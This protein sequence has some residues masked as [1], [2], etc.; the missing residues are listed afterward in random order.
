[1]ALPLPQK[2]L[3]T[4]LVWP[5]NK[6][7]N[8]NSRMQN[9]CYLKFTYNINKEDARDMCDKVRSNIRTCSSLKVVLVP[10]FFK[11]CL[12]IVL[13]LLIL[14]ARDHL[15]LSVDRRLTSMASQSWTEFSRVTIMPLHNSS[16]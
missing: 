11:F 1:M 6:Y 9:V 16:C 7:T 13:F 15:L 3:S 2:T 14:G 12:I 4:K 10:V 5:L 8:P